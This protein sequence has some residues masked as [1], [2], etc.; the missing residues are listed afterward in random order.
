[1]FYGT[2]IPIVSATN[3]D[4]KTI[5]RMS[6]KNSYHSKCYAFIYAKA[7]AFVDI[8]E[9]YSV[10]TNNFYIMWWLPTR[11]WILATESTEKSFLL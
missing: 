4:M 5:I 6:R 3:Y 7:D 11:R 10:G 8:H 1:M 9:Q 2:S